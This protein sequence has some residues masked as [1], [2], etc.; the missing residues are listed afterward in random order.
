MKKLS[1]VCKIVG[2][3]RRTLQEYNKVGL[4]KPTKIAETG[5]WLYDDYAIQKLILIKVFVEAGYERKT[6]KALLESPT[7]DLLDE[8]DR[9]I[10]VLEKK[11]KEIDG[12]INIIKSLKVASKLPKSTLCAMGNID[13]TRI[14]KDKSFSSCLEDSIANSAEYTE[15]DCAD[16]D[17]YLPPLYNILA[18][19]CLMETPEDSAQV[20]AAVEHSCR[21]AIKIAKEGEN[22]SDEELTE[23]ELA[24]FFTKYM[25]EMMNDPEFQHIVEFQCGKG[26]TEYII[27][28]TQVFCDS[29]KSRWRL[30][31]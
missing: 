10:D 17:L 2:V 21:D 8:F 4:L 6:I 27:R 12:M 29:K 28:A 5:Y 7:L 13:V 14:Y 20:Q 25:Q 16:M 1:E 30:E 31:N 3:T 23:M 15:A 11:R 22:D 9:L 19:G 26:A 18:I 24:D